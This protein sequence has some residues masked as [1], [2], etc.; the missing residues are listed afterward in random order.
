MYILYLKYRNRVYEKKKK[1]EIPDVRDKRDVWTI[2]F[3][4]F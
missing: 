1:I 2:E 3:D 4:R